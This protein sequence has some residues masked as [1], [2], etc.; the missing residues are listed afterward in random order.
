MKR[1]FL[2]LAYN[3]QNYCGWQR[4]PNGISV[5]QTLEAALGTLLRTPTSLTGAG[6]TDA[7]VHARRMVAHFEMDLPASPALVERLN[8]I[9]PADIAIDRMVPVRADAHA[10]FDAVSRTYSYYITYR[11]EVFGRE[12]CYRLKKPLDLRRMNDAAQLLLEYSD[13]TSFSKLHTDTATNRCDIREAAWQAEGDGLV[14]T[15]RADRFLRNMVRAIVGTL[16][17]V[18]RGK[19][20]LD[21][22]RRI[23]E[24]CDRAKAGTS[25]PAHAL[26]LT[27]IVYPP[28]L[29]ETE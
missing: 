13:F 15:I 10:R 18:G 1:F 2:Y 5:Q 6:R 11:K 20:S 17:E 3:G 4:Q 27:D 26:Y 7:G 12:L 25:A 9:L 23:I 14:F 28:A 22:F 24:S 29:F 16:I 8:G 21:D 19:C